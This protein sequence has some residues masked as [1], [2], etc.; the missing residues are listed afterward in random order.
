MATNYMQTDVRWSDTV[1]C[2]EPCYYS[3]CGA[4][5]L[6]S[7]LNAYPPE[8]MAWITA[9]GFTSNKSGTYQSGINACLNAFGY[10]G[11]KLT[12]KS[13]AGEDG[14]QLIDIIVTNAIN[15]CCSIMLMGGQETGCVSNY[16]SKAGHYISIVDGDWD[17][18]KV[19]DSANPARTGW[20]AINDFL[21]DMK[22]L[23]ITNCPNLRSL[24]SME[25]NF[26]EIGIGAVGADVRALQLILKS[27]NYYHDTIDSVF[28]ANTEAAVKQAQK[29]SGYLAVDGICGFN[30]WKY[31]LQK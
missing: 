12:T 1:Y 24:R 3:G 19:Y 26:T 11:S 27:M 22:H 31:L 20:H 15:G 28:G 2:G 18:L 21:G 29:E 16:W 17:A 9:N 6:A 30:T 25:F 4:M 10:V 8:I 13:I 7:V 14:Y 5:A 23:W